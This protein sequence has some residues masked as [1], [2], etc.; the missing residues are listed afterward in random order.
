MRDGLTGALRESTS[1]AV[2]AL[3]YCQTAETE[4]TIKSI[5]KVAAGHLTDIPEIPEPYESEFLN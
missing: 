2:H 3:S 4:L 5:W 1:I